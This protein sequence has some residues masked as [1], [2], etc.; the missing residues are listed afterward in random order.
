MNHQHLLLDIQALPRVWKFI[1]GGYPRRGDVGP[2]LCQWGMPRS[3][4]IGSLPAIVDEVLLEALGLSSILKEHHAITLT[5]SSVME[6]VMLI[7][8]GGG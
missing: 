4:L 8:I 3:P 1:L 2:P 5:R 6:S 7:I